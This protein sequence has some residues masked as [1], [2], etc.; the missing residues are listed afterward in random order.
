MKEFWNER[1]AQKI[2]T[3]GKAPNVFFANQINKLQ[4]GTLLLPAEGEGRN[5]VYAAIKGWNVTAFDYSEEGR[6]KALS[7]SRE[8]DVEIDYQIQHADEFSDSEKYDAIALIY[9]HFEAKNAKCYS[10]NLKTA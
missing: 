7:L 1:F 3:Y 5:A 6:K 10:I 8:Y 9:A 2:Y 4:K